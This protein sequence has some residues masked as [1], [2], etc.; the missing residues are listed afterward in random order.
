MPM[1]KRGILDAVGNGGIVAVIRAESVEEGTALA[2]AV[3]RGG[4][5]AVEVT[6]TVPGALKI[7]EK[8]AS[9]AQGPIL[10]AGTVLDPETARACILAGAKFIV[11]PGLN[12]AVIRLCNRY[13]V[14]CL[15]GVGTVT[16]LLRA[17][18]LG[19]EVVKAFPGE[20]LGPSFIKAVRGPVP[21]ARIMPTGGVSPENL[22]EW[23]DAGAFAVGMGGA[24]TKPGGVSR[25]FKLVESTARS[26]M[27]RIA[28]IRG[29]K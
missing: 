22:K 25:N 29:G 10:G 26:I 5:P 17:M 18:E 23:F 8:M 24:L 15:P 7:L 27:E 16:E 9:E 4:I 14:P 20:V 12:E 6:M 28:S 21:S 3:H 1:D 19:A 11:S 13:S 2:G